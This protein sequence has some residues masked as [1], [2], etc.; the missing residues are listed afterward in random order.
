MEKNCLKCGEIIF[1]KYLSNSD[2]IYC[3]RNCN[4][5]AKENH[6]INQCLCGK[7]FKS[8]K[9]RP[10]KYCS[11]SCANGSIVIT[12]KNW[13]NATHE[14]RIELIKQKFEEYVI[15]TDEGCWKWKGTTKGAGYG[16][17]HLSDSF[18]SAHRAS[19]LIHYGEIPNNLCVLHK[20]DNPECTNPSH[21][22]IGTSKDNTQDMIKK[23]RKNPALGET[24]SIKLTNEKV[25][26]IKNLLKKNELTQLEIGQLFNVDQSTISNIKRNKRWK[27]INT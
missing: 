21:L 24:R 26:Q 5:A 23:G 12:K 25:L 14:N 9:S 10:G 18:I 1:I 15:K 19:W 2:Q 22:F 27:H 13:Q 6:Q 8:Y 11:L 3:S 7:T 20:C 16:K 4:N 17:L